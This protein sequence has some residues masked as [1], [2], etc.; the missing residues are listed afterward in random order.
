MLSVSLFL[1]T[2][3]AELAQ[4]LG[5]RL[6]SST[7]ATS[8]SSNPSSHQPVPVT[9]T[10]SSQP[11]AATPTASSQPEAATPIVTPTASSRSPTASSSD[12]VTVDGKLV[13]SKGWLSRWKG[14]HGV[15][16]MRLHGEAAWC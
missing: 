10:V 7:E 13:L 15:F 14:R 1:L 11:E 5:I 4:E 2:K 8:P 3:A 6:R 9:P 12:D 16:S